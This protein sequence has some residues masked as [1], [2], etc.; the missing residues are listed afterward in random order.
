MLINLNYYFTFI[1]NMYHPVFNHPDIV[2]Y[3]V[4]LTIDNYLCIFSKYLKL[5]IISKKLILIISLILKNK[6]IIVYCYWEMLENLNSL[7]DI[8][9]KNKINIKKNS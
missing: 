5:V 3:I 9:F 1:V 2:L 4:K 7:L 6:I 8:N